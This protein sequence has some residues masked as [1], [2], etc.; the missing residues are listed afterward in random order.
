MKLT[1]SIVVWKGLFD[2]YEVKHFTEH[3]PLF[4]VEER[5]SVLSN[6]HDVSRR[7]CA[8][9]GNA[10]LFVIIAIPRQSAWEEERMGEVSQVGE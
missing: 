1:P 10:S 6:L 9:Y 5:A 3:N 8:M 2:E 7:Q 4:P